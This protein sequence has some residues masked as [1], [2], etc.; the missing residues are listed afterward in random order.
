[1]KLTAR[2]ALAQLKV[3]KRRTIWTLAGIIISTAMITAVYST[4]IGTGID[5]ID[6][7]LG[8]TQFRETYYSMIFTLAAILSVF[9]ITISIIVVSNAFR[10]S[11]SERFS[12]FGIL[13]STGATKKQIA[14][15][16]VFEGVFLT[17]IGIPLGLIFGIFLQFISVFIINHFIHEIDTLVVEEFDYFLRFIISPVALLLSTVVAFLTVMLSAWFPANKAAKVPAIN[18]IRGIGEVKVKNKKVRFSR[19][20]Q[21]IFKTEGMLAT[22]FLKRS[23][24]NFRATVISISFSVILV[25][26]AGALFIQLNR[27]A[28]MT[29]GVSDANATLNIWSAER[30]LPIDGVRG[31]TTQLQE[32]L[33]ENE[34]VTMVSSLSMGMTTIPESMLT[35]AMRDA[36]LARWDDMQQVGIPFDSADLYDFHVIMIEVNPDL[37]SQLVELAGV[38]YGQNI[39]INHSVMRLF[40]DGRRIETIPFHFDNQTIELQRWSSES[41]DF[42]DAGYIELH[43][44]ILRDEIPLEI[45]D[46][47][48][49][50]SLSVIVPGHI[51]SLTDQAMWYF[52]VDDVD[53]FMTQAY[54]KVLADFITENEVGYSFNNIEQMRDEQRTLFA[55]LTTITF[56]FVGL[57]IAI[58]LTNVISTISENVRIRAKEF[59]VLQSVGMTR[60][61]IRRMLS[62]EALLCSLKALAWGLPIG[63]VASYL[64][65]HAVGIAA[66]FAYEIPWIPIGV[67]IIGVFIIT[68]VT[69]LYASNQLKDKNI[70]ETIRSGSG[71]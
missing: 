46:S 58:A 23:G 24:T 36:M 17:I 3:N 48:L 14:E 16:V 28:E 29:L 22:K 51:E 35:D 15:T 42:E 55:L 39:L 2:L 70:I 59:A 69:M 27:A 10:V 63:I 33:D 25:I 45:L 54:D 32:M 53:K 66:E 30:T 47:N 31:I 9:I 41:G 8:E 1:M 11:A 71:M 44:Q 12:Q 62:L 38:E 60:G 56:S 5:F 65:H 21:K 7:I 34:R 20:T 19:L 57:L 52:D 61:G 67:S 43:G 26:A 64:L 68:W 50:M 13:K 4:G 37:Y 40:S 49:E 18:A 6:R